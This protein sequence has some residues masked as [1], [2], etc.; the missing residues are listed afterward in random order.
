MY[1]NYV[2]AIIILFLYI[3]MFTVFDQK[4]D[5]ACSVYIDLITISVCFCFAVEVLINCKCFCTS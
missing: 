2:M 4:F 1:L 3:Y 5:H